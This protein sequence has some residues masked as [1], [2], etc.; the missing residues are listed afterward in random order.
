MAKVPKYKKDP[1]YALNYARRK[2]KLSLEHEKVFSKDVKC[3][4]E[5]AILV[6]MDRLIPEVENS[7]FD[8]YCVNSSNS[9]CKNSKTNHST[10]HYQK[11]YLELFFKYLKLSNKIPKKYEEDLLRN[12]EPESLVCYSSCF[13]KRLDKNY[14]SI[15]LTDA[16]KRN[17]CS[18]L[19]EYSYAIGSKLPEEMHNYLL[20][21]YL[22]N[23]ENLV[24]CS[25]FN[26]LKK[27]KNQLIK[28]S[29]VFDKNFTIEQV[30]N[31]L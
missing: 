6:K 27:I 3:A 1:N 5:Y 29:C 28:I 31:Q 26:N 30:I 13:G 17:K 22:A 25:Y 8:F 12:L 14:E 9:K 10:I 21:Q 2:G 15:L 18:H 7:I 24:L 19:V 11:N 4:I 20:S 16:I 23:K